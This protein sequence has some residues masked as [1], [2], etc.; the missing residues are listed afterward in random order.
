[1]SQAP[2]I[3]NNSRY[4]MDDENEVDTTCVGKK[5]D[6]NLN[7]LFIF[8]NFLSEFRDSFFYAFFIQ[9]ILVTYMYYR[10]GRGKYWRV[11][12]Y[13]SIVGL[14]G[15]TVEHSTVVAIC[16][17]NYQGGFLYVMFLV[18]EIFWIFSEFSVPFL[19]FIKIIAISQGKSITVLKIV[20]L[21]LLI[22]FSVIRFMIGNLRREQKRLNSREISLYHGFA[23]GIMAIADIICTIFIIKVMSKAI[24]KEMDK[25]NLK[26]QD[27]SISYYI[28]H[29]SYTILLLVDLCSVLLSLTLI[30]TEIFIPGET[31]TSLVTPFHA[32]KSNFVLILAVDALIFKI[33]A[34]NGT[35]FNS[36]SGNQ[37]KSGFLGGSS[38]KTDTITGLGIGLGMGGGLSTSPYLNSRTNNSANIS[39]KNSMNNIAKNSNGN[40]EKNI[41]FESYYNQLNKSNMEEDN[42]YSQNAQNKN[43]MN[44]KS[45]FEPI[46]KIQAHQMNPTTSAAIPASIIPSLI[47]NNNT[48]YT[49]SIMKDMKSSKK[50]ISDIDTSLTL[51]SYY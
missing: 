40:S 14:L 42:S 8:V 24:R 32:L 31:S 23:F 13:S 22:T 41:F 44:K 18:Q 4:F 45:N 36:S 2:F 27:R 48:S 37:S 38:R 3:P 7:F 15:A 50:G 21:I 17:R 16:N 34:S 35:G 10:V 47:N 46:F 33:G 49:N 20:M 6:G 39:L 25:V 12:L 30:I 19:N 5:I 51:G 1:M 29:S 28:K 9:F 11:L 26:D 43:G